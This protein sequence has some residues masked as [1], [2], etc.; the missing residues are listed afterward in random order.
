M[1]FKSILD[2]YQLNNEKT[3]IKIKERNNR[4]IKIYITNNNEMV[5]SYTFFRLARNEVYHKLLMHYP[6][7]IKNIGTNIHEATYL[8]PKNIFIISLE[9]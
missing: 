3:K 2:E 1:W 5:D 4:E 6:H 7:R 8:I 9:F